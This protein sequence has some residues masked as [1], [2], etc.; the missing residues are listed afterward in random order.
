MEEENQE[1]EE[2]LDS[3]CDIF[4][5]FEKHETMT[6]D[7]PTLIG[8]L[9]WLARP[10]TDFICS[11][12]GASELKFEGE[13]AEDVFFTVWEMVAVS[14]FTMGVALGSWHDCPDPDIREKIK[15]ARIAIRDK[16]ICRY[17]LEARA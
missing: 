6:E 16:I 5:E 15:K 1:R 8:F 3:C 2:F 4:D 13:A 9:E 10:G 11:I 14:A 17:D 12:L 7:E